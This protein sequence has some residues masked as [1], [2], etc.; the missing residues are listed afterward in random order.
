[1]ATMDDHFNR[2]MRKNPTIQDD[3]RGIFKSSS[4]DSPQRSITLSQIRAAY[5]E[6]TGKE[7]PIKGGTRTQ[8]CFI[9]T[10]PYVC[11]FTSRIGTLRF[12]T[13]DINQER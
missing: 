11:C 7:F 5:S 13:I 2:V 10:V 9:L 4:C 12:Y 1:M 8:M 3:L 6:R